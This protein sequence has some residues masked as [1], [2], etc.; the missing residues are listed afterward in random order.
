VPIYYE[1]GRSAYKNLEIWSPKDDLA[2]SYR[3]FWETTETIR[4]VI[5]EARD[6]SPH[7]WQVEFAVLNYN[8]GGGG[9]NGP[10]TYDDFEKEGRSAVVSDFAVDLTTLYFPEQDEIFRRIQTAL[11]NEKNVLFVGPPGTGKTKLARE[12]CRSIVGQEFAIAT[13]TADWS[14]FDT[15]GG[16]QPERDGELVFKPGVFLD[17]FQNSEG[18]PTNEWLIV[19]EINRADIDKAFGSL[20]TALTGENVTLP[21]T[22]DRENQIEILGAESGREKRIEPYR[23]Y[24]PTNWRMLATMNTL[25]K[26]SLYEM[27]YAFMRRWAFVHVPV[28]DDIDADLVEQYVRLWDGLEFD[29]ERCETV[30]ETW[31]VINDVREIGPAIVEDIYRYLQTAADNDLASPIALYVVPQLEGLRDDDLVRFVTEMSSQTPVSRAKLTQFVAEF[32]GLP[33]QRFEDGT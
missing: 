10:R 33:E 18:E 17:R 27:S 12:V 14:T 29:E 16:Y 24:V 20:F 9:G 3:T 5:E 8:V 28:P 30:A 26:T 13:A 4:Q 25:D 6:E 23:Y 22:D 21:F 32:F 7:L 15:I 2:V 1:S 31:R 19:D 11:R